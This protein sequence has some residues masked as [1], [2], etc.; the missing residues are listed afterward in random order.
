MYSQTLRQRQTRMFHPFC[1]DTDVSTIISTMEYLFWAFDSG[2]SKPNIFNS[3]DFGQTIQ[4][5]TVHMVMA[6]LVLLLSCNDDKLVGRRRLVR[7]LD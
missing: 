4:H 6:E 1:E 5:Y 2:K 3:L 7:L